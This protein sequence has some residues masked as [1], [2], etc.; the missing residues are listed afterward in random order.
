MGVFCS[1]H[2]GQFPEF[3][4]LFFFPICLVTSSFLWSIS[5]RIFSRPHL[6]TAQ[7]VIGDGSAGDSLTETLVTQRDW[8]HY[9]ETRSPFLVLWVVKGRPQWSTT[10]WVIG[11]GSLGDPKG[12]RWLSGYKVTFSGTLSNKVTTVNDSVSHRWYQLVTHLS[13]QST[14]PSGCRLSQLC[15]DSNI[16]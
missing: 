5:L 7:W 16:I 1:V 8:G 9:L 11:D 13:L 4:S 2:L 14:A 10:L 3:G 12:L 6:S 15:F